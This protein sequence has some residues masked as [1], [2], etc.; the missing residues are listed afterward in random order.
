MEGALESYK[1]YPWVSWGVAIQH[2][3]APGAYIYMDGIIPLLEFYSV[4][5]DSAVL[6][7]KMLCKVKPM[8]QSAQIESENEELI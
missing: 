5:T 7:R 8:I 4:A 3:W 1:C 2:S 6:Q